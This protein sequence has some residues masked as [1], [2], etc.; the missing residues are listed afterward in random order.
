MKNVFFL[1]SIIFLLSGCSNPTT[2]NLEKRIAELE[3]S[4]ALK[5]KQI[6]G[7]SYLA[8]FSILDSSTVALVSN[9]VPSKFFNKYDLTR[10]SPCVV[11]C[12]KA[13][14]YNLRKCGRLFGQKRIDCEDKAEK[15]WENCTIGCINNQ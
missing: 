8:Y 15:E 12:N 5:D 6:M 13:Y 2:D 11:M 3:K 4:S 7:L 10:P 14:N 1:I 9:K